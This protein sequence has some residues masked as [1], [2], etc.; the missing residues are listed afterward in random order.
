MVDEQ[1]NRVHRDAAQKGGWVA[2]MTLLE[3]RRPKDF[4]RNQ[5]IQIESTVTVKVSALPALAEAEV[6]ALIQASI[7][8]GTKLLPPP[9]TE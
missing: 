5:Q 4:G 7:Q 9:R 2:A 3:R 1:L 6:L 8:G